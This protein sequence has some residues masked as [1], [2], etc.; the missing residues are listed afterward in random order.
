MTNQSMQLSTFR[1]TAV[2]VMVSAITQEEKWV[3]PTTA[4]RLVL[5]SGF[6]FEMRAVGRARE[7]METLEPET[8]YEGVIPQMCVKQYDAK[9]QKFTGINSKVMAMAKA[10]L[11]WKKSKASFQNPL[12]MQFVKA[13]EVQQMD[14]QTI[15]N[16]ICGSMLDRNRF[17]R[18][19]YVSFI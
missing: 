2:K 6:E 9:N 16:L 7:W 14:D 1:D 17:S 12:T 19:Q 15:F 4:G 8:C 5:A 3:M 10:P 11:M 13:N 18:H